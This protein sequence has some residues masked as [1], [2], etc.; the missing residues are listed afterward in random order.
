MHNNSLKFTPSGVKPFAL[1]SG[2]WSSCYR[3]LSNSGIILFLE[4]NIEVQLLMI[5][6]CQRECFISSFNYSNSDRQVLRLWVEIYLDV[7]A[8]SL[9]IHIL[10]ES[11]FILLLHTIQVII[12]SFSFHVLCGCGHFDWYSQH[13]I[14]LFLRVMTDEK[15]LPILTIWLL[16]FARIHFNWFFKL[17]WYHVFSSF[18]SV[19]VFHFLHKI[20]ISG[21]ESKH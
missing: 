17:P 1:S 4:G 11:L 16:I 10:Y 5:L 6:I 3:A 20:T 18:L 2:H 7:Y 9:S 13:Y 19:S 21:L 8:H 15:K 12:N 14:Y